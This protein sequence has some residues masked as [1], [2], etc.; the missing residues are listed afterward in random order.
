[1]GSHCRSSLDSG[2][3]TG[4][5][6]S[7]LPLSCAGIMPQWVNAAP[8]ALEEAVVDCPGARRQQLENITHIDW[9][10]FRGFRINRF[11]DAGVLLLLFRISKLKRQ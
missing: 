9:P 1:M 3:R 10:L 7:P 8:S 11:S 5:S 6:P 2:A 4:G